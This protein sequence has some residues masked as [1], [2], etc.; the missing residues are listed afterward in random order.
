F[1]ATSTATATDTATAT[2][3]PT[4]T[5]TAT[6]THTPTSTFTPTD[7]RTATHTPTSTNTFTDTFTPTNTRTATATPT[8]TN[9]WTATYTATPTKTPT[10]TFTPTNT[11]TY[12]PTPTPTDTRTVTD[13]PTSTNTF[14]NTPTPTNTR[15]ATPTFTPTDTWT[16][17]DTATP[18]KTPTTT[19]T[20]TDTPTF[21]TTAT[22]TDTFTPTPT[23][24][25]FFTK[26]ASTSQI[27]PVTPLFYTLHLYVNSSTSDIAVTDVLPSQMTYLG[28]AA[29]NPSSLPTPAYNASLNQLVWTLPSLA[30]GT[31]QLSYQAQINNM[32]PAGTVLT[33]NAVL[34]YPGSIPL[35]AS[36]QVVALGGYTV[37]IGVYN[38]VGELVA[39]IY[40]QQNMQPVN[41]FTL[42]SNQ[43][44]SLGGAGGAV[45]VYLGGAPV[46]VWNGITAAGTPATNGT[47][48]ITAQSTDGSGNAITVSQTTTVTRP[49]AQVAANIYNEA[50]EVVKHLY[51]QVAGLPNAAL[52]DVQVSSS[53]IQPG[54]DSPNSTAVAQV[55]VKTSSGTVTLSWDGTNDAGAIVTDGT[56]EIGVHWDN[57]N[58]QIQNLTREIS[59]MGA[60]NLNQVVASPN[61]LTGSNT[62]VTFSLQS[63]SASTL[64]VRVY[65]LAGE[66]A[67]TAQ[68]GAGTNQAS[69][70]AAGKASGLY[71]AV[72]EMTNPQTGG[73]VAKQILKLSVFH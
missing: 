65:T 1:T 52:M 26:Q 11:R 27:E 22:P 33:N 16:V 62:T 73:F 34:T 70:N 42:G 40:T 61:V 18:T 4:S 32:V 68:G 59:V 67:G 36:A 15:T 45:T 13:T 55:L 44:T 57:G 28:P 56:Y 72:V 47:Y 7:T 20:S 53:V 48:F 69:W 31:Y 23:L 25:I 9:T 46:A 5:F 49:Y 58:G 29:N 66:L 51:A 63:T 54:I 21:T 17:T 64:R 19:F 35:T 50:G 71:I 43:I 41:A 2:K 30:P 10:N 12:T 6:N 39:T 14:T 8:L 60:K 38:S 3:T 24:Q 37:K